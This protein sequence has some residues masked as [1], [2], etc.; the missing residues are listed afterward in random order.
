MP[1]PYIINNLPLDA[2]GTFENQGGE[3]AEPEPESEH[4]N[5]SDYE[6]EVRFQ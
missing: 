4:D 2:L 3:V 1:E 5:E 6:D